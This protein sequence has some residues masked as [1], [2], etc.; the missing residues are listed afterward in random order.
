MP[1]KLE[2]ARFHVET[3]PS[4]LFERIHQVFAEPRSV[5]LHGGHFQQRAIERDP[6]LWALEN[7]PAD[8]WHIVTAEVRID[9]GK[10][11]HTQWRRVID[12]DAW[13]VVLGFNDTA[14]TTY[15]SSL[16][17][18]AMN[19]EIVTS[20]DLWSKVE[21]VNRSLVESGVVPRTP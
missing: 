7:F 12:H 6:P 10:F 8:E 9:T 2:T 3:G 13:W 5:K 17:K 1:K 4:S 20:G 11:V 15:R 19:E 14:Q 16:A 18:T 21:E